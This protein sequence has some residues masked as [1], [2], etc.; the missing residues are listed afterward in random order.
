[1]PLSVILTVFYFPPYVRMY[2][3]PSVCLG[4]SIFLICNCV[5]LFESCL[6]IYSGLLF[7]LELQEKYIEVAYGHLVTVK[8][9][10]EVQ[11]I[12][13]DDNEKNHLYVL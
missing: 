4:V 10:E 11:T 1:M 13:H 8:K 3:C 9:I 7:Q 6:I 5:Y 12:M 2:F